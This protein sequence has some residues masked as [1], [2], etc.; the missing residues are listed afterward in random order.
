MNNAIFLRA[1]LVAQEGMVLA[2]QAGLVR[3]RI[4]NGCATVSGGRPI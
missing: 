4:G 3:S 1:G 2:T